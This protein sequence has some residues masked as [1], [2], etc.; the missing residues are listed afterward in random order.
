MEKL[1]DFFNRIYYI[2]SRNEMVHI[3]ELKETY[4]FKY[5]FFE[6]WR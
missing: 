2:N 4:D 5:N 1:E 6:I 3:L